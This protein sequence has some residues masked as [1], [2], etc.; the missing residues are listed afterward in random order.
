MHD[1]LGDH[2]VVEHRDLAAFIHAGVDAHAV[3][4]GRR[5]ELDQA[6]GRRQEAAE[7]VFGVDAAFHRPAVDADVGLGQRQLLAVG[8]ADHLLD[9]VQPGDELGDRVLDLQAGVHLEEVE[10]L[11][12]AADHELDRA[13]RLVVHRA[14]QG[15]GLLAHGLA[16]RGVDEGAG[17][18]LDDLL[19]TALDGAVALVEV[20][21]V[22]VP[23]AE[24]LD[25]D[26]ARLEHVLLDEDAVVAE[27]VAGFVH[28]R[29][30]AFV[31][32]LVVE[33]HAQAL[34]ATAGR[35]LDHHRVADLL[36]DLDRLVGARNGV[37]VAGDGVHAS[38][39]RELLG[40]DLVAHLGDRVVLR[41]DELDAFLFQPAR[42]LGVLGQKAVARVHRLGAGLLAGGDDLVDD[43]VG[44][45]RRR[46]ANAH[47]LVGQVHE[48]RVLVRLGVHRH[49]GDAHLAG[50]L[51]DAA[52]NLAAVCNQDLL[53][54]VCFPRA[55]IRAGC[56]RACATDSRAACP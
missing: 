25:L 28:A 46:R 30:E 38:G 27:G 41:A 42:E 31:R 14:R 56:C 17:R 52:S 26:V 29:R 22:A 5:L 19:V 24:D 55:A 12:R 1:E 51:D 37:V 7:R 45:F 40:L 13:G 8:D 20:H 23:V 21:V 33:G 34:A 54:H 16:H 50:G 6:A 18:L 36:R 53:E 47:G 49:G 9:E 4:F 15:H 32:L 43:Q 35:G 11:G 10:L 3:A 44:L 39:D 48:Q 2:R